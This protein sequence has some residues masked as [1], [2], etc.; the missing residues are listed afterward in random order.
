VHKAALSQVTRCLGYL[1]EET[2]SSPELKL[3]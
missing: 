1:T 3:K 2:P